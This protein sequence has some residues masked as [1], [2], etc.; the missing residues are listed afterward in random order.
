V[1]RWADTATAK[2]ENRRGG[3]GA[4]HSGHV[5]NIGRFGIRR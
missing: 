4:E 1:I 5:G 3:S 2:G